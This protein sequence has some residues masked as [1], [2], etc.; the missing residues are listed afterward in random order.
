MPR[1]QRLA[2]RILL[3]RVQPNHAVREAAQASHLGGEPRLRRRSSNATKVH[4]RRPTT[5][6]EGRPHLHMAAP[7]WQAVAEAIDSWLDGVLDAPIAATQQT[8]G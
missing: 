5:S 1:G 7:D 6:S 8:T 2:P 4:R 3:Q